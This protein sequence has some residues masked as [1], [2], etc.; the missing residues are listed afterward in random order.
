MILFLL[1][2]SWKNSKKMQVRTKL[3]NN[4]NKKGVKK[5]HHKNTVFY[6]DK[7]GNLVGGEEET[8]DR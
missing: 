3:F 6:K 4:N 1:L 7:E 2:E 8:I 5:G